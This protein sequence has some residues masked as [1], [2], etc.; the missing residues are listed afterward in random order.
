[1][2]GTK[3]AEPAG[4]P[5]TEAGRLIEDRWTRPLVKAGW[6]AIPNVIVEHQHALGL[7]PTDINVI[8]HLVRHWWTP[9]KLP[10]PAKAT[11]AKAMDVHP[12]TV[13]RSVRKMEKAGLIRRKYRKSSE[14]G[15][16]TNFYDFSGLIAKATPLADAALEQREKHKR[17]NAAR[18]RRGAKPALRVVE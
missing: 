17:E 3:S 4:K 10:H 18:L 5:Q 16:L 8:L 12:S 1:M 2:P 11:I 9:E 15:N 14:R 7:T 6:S 13:Q